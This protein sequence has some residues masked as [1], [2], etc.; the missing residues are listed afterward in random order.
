[1]P[2]NGCL[3]LKSAVTRVGKDTLLINPDWVEARAFGDMKLIE[4]DEAEPSG[5]NG[6]WLGEVLIYPA[7]YPK[8][9]SRLRA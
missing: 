9:L 4:V 6:L 7:N 2:V 3:H 5:G 8:T 1:M